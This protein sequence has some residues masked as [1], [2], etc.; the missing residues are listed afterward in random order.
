MDSMNLNYQSFCLVCFYVNHNCPFRQSRF[1][2]NHSVSNLL[3]RW[4]MTNS[5]S[6]T[7]IMF[8][9]SSNTHLYADTEDAHDGD[10]VER[11]A[12]VLAVVQ[13]RH[14]N[15]PGFP[16]QKGPEQLKSINQ[17]FQDQMSLTLTTTV[18]FQTS[19]LYFHCFLSP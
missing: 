9:H 15:R 7:L 3:E 13:S 2:G 18:Y 10:V 4:I 17:V 8:L 11:H 14:L 16:G 12:D 1:L 5:D 6:D 19:F